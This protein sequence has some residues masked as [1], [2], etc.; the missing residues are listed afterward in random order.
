MN[1]TTTTDLDRMMDRVRKLLAKADDPAATKPEADSFRAKAEELIAKYR[2]DEEAV[3]AKST[4]M[5]FLVPIERD[6]LICNNSSTYRS[7]YYAIIYW[8]AQHVGARITTNYRRNDEGVQEYVAFLTGFEVDLRFAEILYTSAFLAFQA[9]TE[10]GYDPSVDEETNTIFKLRHM[11]VTRQKIAVQLWGEAVLKSVPAHG[12]VQKIYEAECVRRDV[13]FVHGRGVNR[14]DFLKVYADAFVTELYYR[15]ATA[16]QAAN[17]ATGNGPEMVLANRQERVDA[18]FYERYPYLK[19]RQAGPGEEYVPSEKERREQD[20]WERK[21]NVARAK[22]LGSAAGKAGI[23][24]G[25]EAA[26]AV[27]LGG[28]RTAGRVE[29]Q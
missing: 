22:L 10:P 12:K 1:A 26:Q 5:N 24:A 20:R 4:N 11:G 16:R 17:L 19:P 2:I 18:A 7:S 27:D 13:P 23:K 28:I 9:H 29:G 3:Y 21:Q 15:L 6:V 25:R 8:I 14:A